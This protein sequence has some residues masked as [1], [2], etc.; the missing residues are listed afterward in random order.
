MVKKSTPLGTGKDADIINTEVLIVGGGLVGATLAVALGQA[1]LDVA[2]VDTADP[3]ANLDAGFDGR[4]SA[5]ALATQR[6]LAGLGLWTALQPQAAPI[7][8]IRVSEGNSPFFLHYDH[9]ETGD[10]AFGYMVENRNLRTAL[11]HRLRDLEAVR[12]CAPASVAALDRQGHGV[13]ATLADG[14]SIRARLAV[15]ADGRA[16]Q[17]REGAGIKVTNWSYQQFGIVCT[18]AHEKC[19]DFVA[20]EHF[21]P[22]GPFAI[23]PLMGDADRPGHCSS[24]VWTERADLAPA[25]MALDDA[26]FM[27]ELERRFGDFL[28]AIEVVGPRW[29]YPLSLQYAHETISHRLALVGDAAHAMHPIAGQGLNMGLRDV[30]ALAEVVLDARRLGL[31]IGDGAVL[32]RYQRWRRF[33]NTLMLAMTDG[34]NRLFSNN[35]R[36][37]RLARDLGLAA[38]NQLPPLK[39]FFMRHAMG[40]VGDL[41]RLMRNQSL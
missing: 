25:I 41:P 32:E 13:T 22:A 19:H 9:H 38:V 2:V 28:G 39:K 24:I 15:A 1:G 27:V 36:P 21:L 31:D 8:D 11:F 17:T 7:L 26:S 12:V 37:L 40:L 6:V 14:R 4:A 16:S 10:E 35:I 34:L 23:L 20:N 18:V 5:I 30:A 29:S 3:V 33:D